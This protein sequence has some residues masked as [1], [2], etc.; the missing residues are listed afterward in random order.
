MTP[1]GIPADRLAFLEKTFQ[2]A[3][4]SAKLREYMEARGLKLEASSAA[5]FRKVIDAEYV[6]MGQVMK[7]IGLGK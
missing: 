6:A 7:A 1:K 2:E 4:R 3:A 5:E